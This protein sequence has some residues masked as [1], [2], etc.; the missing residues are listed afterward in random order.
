[1]AT[2]PTMWH[3][4]VGGKCWCPHNLASLVVACRVSSWCYCA[5][6]YVLH[7]ARFW[8]LLVECTWE[9][10]RTLSM[11]DK[12]V[13]SWG[14]EA[15]LA[16]HTLSFDS[17]INQLFN[18]MTHSIRQKDDMVVFSSLDSSNEVSFKKSG[19]QGKATWRAVPLQCAYGN[20]PIVEPLTKLSQPKQNNILKF[21]SMNFPCGL[22][23][24][25]W[26]R[27]IS[28]AD[29]SFQVLDTA[30]LSNC[31]SCMSLQHWDCS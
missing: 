29:G 17:V 3:T 6:A 15:V 26:Q 16:L 20:W 4:G 25:T 22:I 10:E 31:Q 12:C 11:Q 1:M 19:F 2:N 9:Y 8:V 30:A 7:L 23:S 24:I 18:G 28:W 5:A 21:G 13:H 14:M 27:N